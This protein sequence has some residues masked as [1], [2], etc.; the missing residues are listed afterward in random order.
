VTSRDADHGSLI[1]AQDGVLE[2]KC[3]GNSALGI[4]EVQ[5]EGKRR[6]STRDFLNGNKL[7]PGEILG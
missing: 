6:M 1:E 5:L 7:S 3:G 2:V 4:K